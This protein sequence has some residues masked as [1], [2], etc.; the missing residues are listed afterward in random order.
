MKTDACRCSKKNNAC[1]TWVIKLFKVVNYPLASRGGTTDVALRPR[2]EPARYWVGWL[3]RVSGPT[4][5]ARHDGRRPS[6][7]WSACIARTSSY[8]PYVVA[9]LHASCVYASNEKKLKM[10]PLSKFFTDPKNKVCLFQILVGVSRNVCVFQ[11]KKV[12]FLI[13]FFFMFS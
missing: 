9:R 6:V 10:F 3:R 13:F 2:D 11:K 5:T 4:H 8:E 7:F 12:V 1:R